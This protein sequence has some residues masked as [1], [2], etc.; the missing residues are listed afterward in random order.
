MLYGSWAVFCRVSFSCF[1][2]PPSPSVGQ[3]NCACH[4]PDNYLV[5][6]KRSSINFSF[7]LSRILSIKVIYILI[8]SNDFL[9]AVN[10]QDILLQHSFQLLVMRF[11]HLPTSLIQD[12]HKI[13]MIIV[14]RRSQRSQ[15]KMVIFA[16][17]KDLF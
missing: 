9:S 5:E 7:S 17:T 12:Y 13:V 15:A 16:S 4:Y 10:A 11:S 2:S 1:V 6:D 14:Y 3:L 8:T